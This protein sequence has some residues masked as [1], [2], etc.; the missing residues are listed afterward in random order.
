MSNNCSALRVR[1][2]DYL[3]S[4]SGA[5]GSTGGSGSALDLAGD[6]IEIIQTGGHTDEP[7]RN[8][9]RHAQQ[10]PLWPGSTKAASLE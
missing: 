2:L 1:E 9:K 6:G 4:G 3:F 8:D 5:S 10:A 7:I